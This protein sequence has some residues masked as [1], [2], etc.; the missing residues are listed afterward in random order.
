MKNVFWKKRT[1]SK[2]A[3]ISIALLAVVAVGLLLAGAFTGV[4]TLAIVPVVA[5]MSDNKFKALSD[6]QLKELSAEDL[7]KYH[8]DF[9][10]AK[11]AE[12]ES[13]IEAKADVNDLASFKKE[14]LDAMLEQSKA[15]NS[16]IERQV[17]SSTK[18][19]TN[20][21]CVKAAIKE[22]KESI[23]DYLQ[24]KRDNFKLTV[25]ADMTISGSTTGTI[26]APFFKTGVSL[27][28][29]RSTLFLNLINRIPVG[30]N[31]IIYWNQEVATVGAP[32]V[33]AE[34][35]AKPQVEYKLEA[36]NSTLQKIAAF[37]TI[38]K[39]ML[40][41]PFLNNFIQKR[42]LVDLELKIDDT[43][44]AYII[45]SGSTAFSA[46]SSA[47]TIEHANIYDAIEAAAVQCQEN[48]F[49]PNYVMGH[50]RTLAKI[51][52]EK[53]KDG[54][55]VIAPFASQDG[56]M[57]DGLKV[58]ANAGIAEGKLFVLDSALIDLYVG[59]EINFEMGYNGTDFKENK[60]SLVGEAFVKTVVDGNNKKGIIYMDV[61]TAIEA[62]YKAS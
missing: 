17:L 12:L 56:T 33:T 48:H 14:I 4:A 45:A 1:A 25:K 60:K 16:A 26:I 23:N 36:K 3:F 21:D 30:L 15:L 53:N 29:R 24:G 44:I 27:I 8:Q 2:L 55:Y 11:N 39:E 41:E 7:V 59:E 18:G 22:A 34:G 43:I 54:D 13:K 6:E 19:E 42:M 61:E 35:V 50:P 52:Q 5:W 62:L 49:Q 28:R 32:A 38:S 20:D 51:K 37:G 58:V 10:E 46:G 31:Q 9:L 47:G 40:A 57:I